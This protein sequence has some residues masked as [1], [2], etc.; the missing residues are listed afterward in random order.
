MFRILLLERLSWW[1]KRASD[2]WSCKE[3]EDDNCSR[4][5]IQGRWSRLA[6]RS[7]AP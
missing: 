4:G 5:A 1:R 3:N 7:V 2:G 6:S